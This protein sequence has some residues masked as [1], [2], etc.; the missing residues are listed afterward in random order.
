ME[1]EWCKCWRTKWH[2]DV[3]A[4]GAGYCKHCRNP[5][6]YFFIPSEREKT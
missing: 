6:A 1:T 4:D 5:I 3:M 2:F